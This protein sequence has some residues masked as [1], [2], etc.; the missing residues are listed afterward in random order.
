MYSSLKTITC[1]YIHA[2]SIQ[3]LYRLLCCPIRII[4]LAYTRSFVYSNTYLP[5]LLNQ[6]PLSISRHTSGSAE[7][8]MHANCQQ[9]LIDIIKRC[10]PSPPILWPGSYNWIFTAEVIQVKRY[11]SVI[12]QRH[13]PVFCTWLDAFL[14]HNLYSDPA[15]RLG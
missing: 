14:T 9:R 8:I 3:F 12:N 1:S 11:V 15:Y 5:Y 4:H 6:M 13:I 7:R 10:A 2:Q